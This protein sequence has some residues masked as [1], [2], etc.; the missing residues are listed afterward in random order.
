MVSEQVFYNMD[1]SDTLQ[2]LQQCYKIEGTMI[3]DGVAITSFDSKMPKFFLQSHSHKVVKS[4]G[5]FFDA[6]GSYQEWD[7][8]AMGYHIRLQEELA[9]FEDIHG[10][11]L[12]EYFAYETGQGYSISH[13]AL[14]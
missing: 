14:T 13:L 9:N 8:P 3:A 5:L 4:D 10:T 11:Y 1:N 6:I 7:N 2:Q 12:K